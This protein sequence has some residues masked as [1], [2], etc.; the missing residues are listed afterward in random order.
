MGDIFLLF[1]PVSSPPVTCQSLFLLPQFPVDRPLPLPTRLTP[2]TSTPTTTM[3]DR[4]DDD[5]ATSKTQGFK[6]GEK[7]SLQ[8]Y[9]ELG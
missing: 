3:A 2:T 4:H 5:L 8:E 9:Q 7:K 1:P 6:V